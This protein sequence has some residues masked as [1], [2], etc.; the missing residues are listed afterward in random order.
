MAFLEVDGK[1][2]AVPSGESAIG[3][4]DGNFISLKGTGVTPRH[5]VIVGT[6][7]GQASVSRADAGAETFINGVR[8]GPQPAPLLHG[9]KIEVGEHE[10]L[11]VDERRSGSTQFV[12]AEDLAGLNIDPAKSLKRAATG[13]TGGRLVS[14]TDGREYSIVGSTL[15]LGR[16]AGCDVVVASKR[17]SRRHSEIVAT[18]KGYVII[19][20]STN[21]TFVNGERIEG[22]RLLAR[23]DVVRVGDDEFRFYADP[24]KAEPEPEP[25]EAQPEP[26]EAPGPPPG[27]AYR[28]GDTLHGIP[29]EQVESAKFPAPRGDRPPPGA[30]YRLNDTMHGLPPDSGKAA[31][32]PERPASSG[33]EYRLGDTMMGIPGAARPVPGPTAP[34]GGTLANLVGRSGDFKGKRFPI[35]V[36]VVNIGRADYNDVVLID[37]TVSTIH[38]KLQRREG[39]WVLID[40]DSTNGTFVDGDRVEGESPIAPG[41][42]VRFGDVSTVFEPTDDDVGMGGGGSTR[43]MGALGSPSPGTGDVEGSRGQSAPPP[44]TGGTGGS[45]DDRRD[46]SGFRLWPFK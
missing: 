43:M 16:D 38:A 28:L 7:D 15:V 8:L 39:V 12:R 9:D 31:P 30:E 6:P 26:V 37:S 10:L 34:P 25:V 20:T 4:A 21:G 3:S 17:V 24:V 40:L 11:F 14:L 18:P 29:E 35:R 27:A 36:P 23:A 2:H 22:E 1:R 19:D 42:I 32:P 44:P 13:A 41:A 45:S 46:R 5:L 33:A